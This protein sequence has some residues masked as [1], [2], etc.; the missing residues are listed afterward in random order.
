MSQTF[1]I[2]LPDDLQKTLLNHASQTQLTPEQVIIQTLIQRFLPNPP[3]APS[4][5]T[6]QLLSLIGTLDLK[7]TDLAENHDRYIGETLSQKLRN[8]E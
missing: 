6:E 5:E 3:I 7:T 2:E 8:A 4:P 1:I